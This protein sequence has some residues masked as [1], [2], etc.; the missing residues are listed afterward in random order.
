MDQSI[1]LDATPSRLHESA[2]KLSQLVKEGKTMVPDNFHEHDMESNDS[3]PTMM[4]GHTM[5]DESGSLLDRLQ[6]EFARLQRLDL[7][8]RLAFIEIAAEVG[9]HRPLVI[10][11]SV[12]NHPRL[13]IEDASW[14]DESIDEVCWQH[15]I[16]APS[17]A[18][19]KLGGVFL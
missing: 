13:S 1:G 12:T 3:I 4:N 15:L 10:H 9:L 14:A 16:P 2:Q 11:R 17:G 8:I 5:V 6:N 18:S 7:Q 19:Q